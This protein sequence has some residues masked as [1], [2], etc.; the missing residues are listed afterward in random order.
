MLSGVNGDRC[1]SYSLRRWYASIAELIGLPHEDRLP[2]GNWTSAAFEELSSGAACAL[3]S[4]MPVR[5]TDAAVENARELGVKQA[6]LRAAESVRLG[7][8]QKSAEWEQYSGVLCAWYNHPGGT[9][10]AAEPVDAC[11][12]DGVKPS[13]NRSSGSRSSSSSSSQASSSDESVGDATQNL[14]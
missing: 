4:S 7:V 13:R 2:L 3:A 1:P 11:G 9:E 10:Q 12:S 14:V 6:V 8:T 5:Y